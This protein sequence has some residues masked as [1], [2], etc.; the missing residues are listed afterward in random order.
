VRR[1]LLAPGVE[2]RFHVAAFPSEEAAQQFHR[3]HTEKYPPVYREGKMVSGYHPLT[4]ILPHT[5]HH[6]YVICG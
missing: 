6:A 5:R 2:G 3:E 1:K 4:P